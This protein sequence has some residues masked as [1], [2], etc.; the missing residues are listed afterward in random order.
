MHITVEPRESHAILHLRGE[1]DTYYVPMLQEEIDGLLKAGVRH[2]VLN[3]RLVKFINSTALGAMIKAAK[4]LERE[5]GKL[6]ISRPS[7]FCRD[8]LEKVGLDRV[9]PI[10]DTDEAAAAA[11]GADAPPPALDTER[12]F[13]EDAS[14]VIFAPQDPKRIGHFMPEGGSR[15]GPTNPVHGHT[16]GGRWAGLGRMAGLDEHS[17]W[18]T[19]SGGAGDLSPFEMAQF[20]AIGT[21]WRLKF[22]LPLLRRGFCEAV[23]TVSEVEERPDGVKVRATFDQLDEDTRASIKQYSAD[24]AYLKD[25]LKRATDPAS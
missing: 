16:F 5:G 6:V 22:R 14:T 10:F 11:L 12:V 19:W 23:A 1:F 2:A 20:L 18:F 24:M 4:L 9:V 8:I 3:L 21:A 17:V 7:K 15:G 25:E 13:E